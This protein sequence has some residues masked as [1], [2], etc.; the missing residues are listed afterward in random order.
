MHLE[1]QLWAQRIKFTFYHC[2]DSLCTN[3]D[4][5]Y[6]LKVD[7]GR[8]TFLSHW[9]KSKE[10]NRKTEMKQK[11]EGWKEG[12]R[13]QEGRKVHLLQPG[14]EPAEHRAETSQA[15]HTPLEKRGQQRC[16]SA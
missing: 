9:L 16:G 2:Q 8:S 15:P 7:L 10:K 13:G 12:E 14:R 11:T 1:R 4:F 5:I 6:G 3:I